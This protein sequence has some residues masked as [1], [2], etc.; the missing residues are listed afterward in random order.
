MIQFIRYSQKIK[1]E[2]WTTDSDIQGLGR[3]GM[4]VKK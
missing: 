3:R 2:Q 4:I 1:L